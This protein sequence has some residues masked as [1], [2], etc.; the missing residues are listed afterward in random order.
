VVHFQITRSNEK[1]EDWIVKDEEWWF[2]L[3]IVR[4]KRNVDGRGWRV[5]VQRVDCEKE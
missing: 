1:K 5:V 4:R 2:K 3:L